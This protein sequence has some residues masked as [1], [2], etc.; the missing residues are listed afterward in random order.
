M[1]NK[2]YHTVGTIQISKSIHLKQ[3]YMIVY[4]SGL[5]QAQQ[6]KEAEFN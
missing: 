5:V 2:K 4:F 1:K 3:K 6:W